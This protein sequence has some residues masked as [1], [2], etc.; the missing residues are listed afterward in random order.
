GP[1][2]LWKSQDRGATW[3][4]ALRFPMEPDPD[5]RLVADPSVPGTLYWIVNGFVFKI[6]GGGASWTCFPGSGTQCLEPFLATIE[7]AID[8]RDPDTVYATDGQA[9]R[10]PE[11]AG[12]PIAPF[13]SVPGAVVNRLAATAAPGVL[14]AWSYA[15]LSLLRVPCLARSDDGGRTWKG[16]LTGQT[17]GEPLIDPDEPLTVRMIVGDKKEPRLWTSRDGG[18]TWSKGPP[19]PRQGRLTSTSAA[20][21]FLA[22]DFGLFRSLDGGHT[23]QAAI[24][25]LHASVG[26]LAVPSPEPG[27]VYAGV[28]TGPPWLLE[29]STNGG[30]TWSRLPLRAPTAIAVDPSDPRHLLASVLRF[31]R[32]GGAPR[33]RI[34][35]SLDGGRSWKDVSKNVPRLTPHAFFVQVERLAFD[36]ADP[37]I[38]YAGTSGSGFL[39]STDRG[40]TWQGLN[41]GLPFVRTCD[42]RFCSS[43]AVNELAADAA[44]RTLYITFERE[45][46]RSDNRGATW[47]RAG[48]GM[49]PGA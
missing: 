32:D 5:N 10:G 2:T 36:R 8:P 6:T 41:Q 28:A 17:C 30:R 3:S 9:L 43:N 24:Q 46:Y 26:V 1:A 23:W 18:A 20:G 4:E 37:R 16:F 12:F 19:A 39:R 42:S 38:V 44:P 11:G 13:S 35:E 47:T 29:K 31:P 34:V 25:G 22:F 15:P 21:L 48:A 7:V 40:R 49:P 27:V 33:S 14:Y 45:V